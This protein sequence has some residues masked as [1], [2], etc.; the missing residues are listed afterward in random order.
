MH[1]YIYMYI[2]IYVQIYIYIYTYIYIYVYIYK[3]VEEYTVAAAGVAAVA[4]RTAPSE[5]RRASQTG[6]PLTE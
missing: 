1:I 3:I 5:A 2:F 4:P 6:A